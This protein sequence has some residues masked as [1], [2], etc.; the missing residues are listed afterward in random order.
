MTSPEDKMDITI[1]QYTEAMARAYDDGYE[2]AL[3]DEA[4]KLAL[5]DRKIAQEAPLGPYWE[6]E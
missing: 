6:A 4:A 2:Q 1:R 5:Q 3:R